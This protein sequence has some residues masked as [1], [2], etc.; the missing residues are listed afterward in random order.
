MRFLA[1]IVVA[2]ILTTPAIGA[3]IHVAIEDYLIS[4][5]GASPGG[6]VLLVGYQRSVRGF[7]PVFRRIERVIDTGGDGR[8]QLLLTSP[9]PQNSFWVAIDLATGDFGSAVPRD[10]PGRGGTLP[11][12]AFIKGKKGKVEAIAADSDHAF[13]VVVR[14]AALGAWRGSGGDGAASDMDGKANGRIEFAARSLQKLKGADSPG[15]ELE[16]GDV[17]FVFATHRM[18]FLAGV[19]KP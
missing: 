7:E 1:P 11:S 15:D 13:V 6:Q 19:V 2:L 16:D 9:N 3:S 4:V 5:R 10:R 12:K 18:N 17:V 14:P 8:V